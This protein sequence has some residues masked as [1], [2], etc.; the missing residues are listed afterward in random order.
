M[1]VSQPVTPFNALPSLE[2]FSWRGLLAPPYDNVSL[3]GG[4]N[5]S[6][7]VYPYIDGSGHDNVGASSIPM[8]FKLYFL[9]SLRKDLFPGL[10][11]DWKL[12]VVE[13]LAA[14]FLDL[15][16]DVYPGAG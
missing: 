14:D 1:P 4:Y 15:A 9:N 8:Q 3:S 13:D 2:E 5:Q 16:D 12:A 11:L 10:F 6:E 7:K